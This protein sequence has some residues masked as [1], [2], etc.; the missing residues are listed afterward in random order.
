MN[1]LIQATVLRK[2]FRERQVVKDVTLEIKEGEVI[3]LM[4][5]NGAGKSTIIGMLLDTI[6]V[7]AGEITY[8]RSDFKKATGI[9][10]QSTPFFEG[11]TVLENVKLFASIYGVKVSEPEIQQQLEA[12]QL[13]EMKKV[14]ASK[15]SIGQQKRLAIALA[16]LHNPK[17]VFLD[18]PSA[19]LDPKGQK[20]IRKLIEYLKE[21][22]V[23]VV[24][25]SHDMLEVNHIADRLMFINAGELVANGTP[26]ELYKRYGV[27]TMEDLYDMVNHHEGDER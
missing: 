9:Q 14:I 18:E 19:G 7:D 6:R 12:Y 26:C 21:K 11:Y 2:A 1:V 22:N 15:L 5:P 23:T 20:K 10:L 3:A 24:F 17:L 8:W 25:A 4:G 27:K 16:T 13:E